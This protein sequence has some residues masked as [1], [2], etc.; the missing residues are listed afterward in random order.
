MNDIQRPDI[1]RIEK[2]GYAEPYSADSEELDINDETMAEIAHKRLE[3]N[4]RA[5]N[6]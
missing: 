3:A 1:T 6:A 5:D 4:R 2:D